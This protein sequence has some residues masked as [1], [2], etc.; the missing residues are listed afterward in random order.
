MEQYSRVMA[1][2]RTRHC[3]SDS[4]F[5]VTNYRNSIRSQTEK[6]QSLG[7][8]KLFARQETVLDSVLRVFITNTSMDRIVGLM[9]AVKQIIQRAK[10]KG[11]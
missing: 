1:K 11:A 4:A 9:Q 8:D 7:A 3:S 10:Q 6:F 2:V 5:F